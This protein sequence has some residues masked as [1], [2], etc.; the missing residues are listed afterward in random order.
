VQHEEPRRSG[1]WFACASGI[2]DAHGRPK[3]VIEAITHA[4]ELGE[5]AGCKTD[6]A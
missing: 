2:P 1:G 6:R 4:T 3:R 5:K